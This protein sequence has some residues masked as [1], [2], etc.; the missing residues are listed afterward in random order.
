[1]VGH[2]GRHIEAG[3]APP[4]RPPREV[5]ILSVRKKC[6]VEVLAPKGDVL[7]HGAAVEGNRPARPEDR[8][9]FTQVAPRR[10]FARAAI[11]MPLVRGHHHAGGVEPSVIVQAKQTPGGGA[12]GGGRL[13]R[14]DEGAE[15]PVAED[16][17]GVETQV[18][19][20]RRAL[21][22]R[23]VAAR[24]AQVGRRPGPLVVGRQAGDER[25]RG[26]GRLVVPDMERERWAP[27]GAHR[28][29]A[30]RQEGVGPPRDDPDEDGRHATTLA[31]SPS[32]SCRRRTTRR[33]H[34]STA[35][36]R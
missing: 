28:G 16:G 13:E 31:E 21:N 35:P 24:E 10:R 30:A 19:G 27:L 18:V 26:L 6:M 29:D 9:G 23:V 14:L 5:C 34:P 8:L 3:P 7:E 22:Q 36:A 25:A 17:I 4:L 1:M 12:H 11:E 15:V 20:A 32:R 33:R 2:G